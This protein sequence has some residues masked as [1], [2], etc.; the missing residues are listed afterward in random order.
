MN[1]A[2]REGGNAVVGFTATVGLLLI[3][4]VTIVSLGL[5]WFAREVMKDSVAL[6]ARFAALDGA[7]EE[8][9]RERTFELITTTLPP[10]FADD[11]TITYGPSWVIVRACAPAPVLGLL[12]PI[13]I[14]VEGRA[15]I[16]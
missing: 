9:A 14:D 12:L 13:T 4:T 10:A 7:S 5:T 16:E 15:T 3:V 1:L 11:I 2:K 6:G 8:V